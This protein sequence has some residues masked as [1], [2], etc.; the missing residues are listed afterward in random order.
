LPSAAASL[1]LA[2]LSEVVEAAHAREHLVL[3]CIGRDDAILSAEL[4]DRAPLG[5]DLRLEQPHLLFDA[6]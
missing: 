6:R 2:V 4:L 1:S 3:L 5:R